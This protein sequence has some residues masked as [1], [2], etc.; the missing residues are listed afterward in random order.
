MRPQKMQ[1]RS[2]MQPKRLWTCERGLLV[3]RKVHPL[4][5]SVNLPKSQS[6]EWQQLR[7]LD[8]LRPAAQSSWPPRKNASKANIARHSTFHSNSGSLVKFTA[9][10]RLDRAGDLLTSGPPSGPRPLRKKEVLV[11]LE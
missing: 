7:Q 10:R 3:D 1:S 2:K 6:R 4:S 8:Q 9:I 11:A 5:G